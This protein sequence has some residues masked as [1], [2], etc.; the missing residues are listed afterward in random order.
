MDIWQAGAPQI[1][2]LSPDFYNPY[3]RLYC[4]LYIRRNNPF[5]IPEIRAEPGNA[6]KCFML[7][8]ITRQWGFLLFQLNLLFLHWMNRWL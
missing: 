5:F 8:G 4:D 3:F 2:F 7:L 1:D 6:A